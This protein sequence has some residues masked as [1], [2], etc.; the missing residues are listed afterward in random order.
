M[1]SSRTVFAFS[2]ITPSSKRMAAEAAL[3]VRT[4]RPSSL[5]PR[6]ALPLI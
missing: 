2:L 1:G 5:R 6:V 4:V 3:P